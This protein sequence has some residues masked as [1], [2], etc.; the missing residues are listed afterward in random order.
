MRISIP[1]KLVLAKPHEK[2]DLQRGGSLHGRS[3][4]AAIEDPI[5]M[6]TTTNYLTARKIPSMTKSLRSLRTRTP[7]RMLLAVELEK[8]QP[9]NTTIKKALRMKK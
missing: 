2:L 8:S 3:L 4:A 5:S 6:T 7:R 1:P 9:N